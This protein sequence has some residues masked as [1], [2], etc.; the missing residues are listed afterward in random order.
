M[1]EMIPSF[2]LRPP[3]RATAAWAR[4]AAP[5][6]PEVQAAGGKAAPRGAVP[7]DEV[8]VRSAPTRMVPTGVA[9]AVLA[10]EVA[11]PPAGRVPPA[12]PSVGWPPRP[13]RSERHGL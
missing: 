11:E 12:R 1:S 3:R 5:S 4:R 9:E 7:A 10:G 8:A 13:H 6:A 2:T